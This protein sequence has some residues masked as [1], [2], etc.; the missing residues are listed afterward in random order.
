MDDRRARPEATLPRA[1]RGLFLLTALASALATASTTPA[2]AEI[3]VSGRIQDA[4]GHVPEGASVALVESLGEYERVALRADGGLDPEPIA[5][6]A[7]GKDGRFRFAA[8]RP[9]PYKVVVEAAGFVTMEHLLLPLLQNTAL[10]T[11]ELPA[12]REIVLRVSDAEGQALPAEIAFYP[13]SNPRDTWRP[14]VRKLTTDDKGRVA[15]PH[16][17]GEDELRLDVLADGRPLLSLDIDA[18]DLDTEKLEKEAPEIRLEDGVTGTVRVLDPRG[19]PAEDVV[20]FQGAGLLPFGKTDADGLITLTLETG[21]EPR[22]VGFLAPDGANRFATIVFEGKVEELPLEDPITV[23]GRVLDLETRDPLV[24]A[25]VW[26]SR[27]ATAFTDNRGRYEVHLPPMR[28]FSVRATAEG[29]GIGAA[30]AG[31]AQGDGEKSVDMPLALPRA[32][33]ARGRVVDGESRPV[34]DVKIKALPTSQEAF[35]HMMRTGRG[36][37]NPSTSG[38]SDADGRFELAFLPAATGFTL[39]LEKEGFSPVRHEVPPA[40]EGAGRPAIEIRMEAGRVGVGQVVDAAGEP[41]AGATVALGR[42]E[43]DK[44]SPMFFIMNQAED[45]KNG[46]A[47]D[48][49][50]RFRLP[51]LANGV[52]DLEV[53]ADGYAPAEIP[54]VRIEGPPGEVDLGTVVLEIGLAVSGLVVDPNGAPVAEAG[55]SVERNRQDFRMRR[56]GDETP[57]TRTDTTGRF[58]VGP[59]REGESLL[60]VVG[61]EGFT[62]ARHS[63]KI[64]ADP[65]PLRIVLKAA[66]R[67]SGRVVD[68]DGEPVVS[69]WLSARPLDREAWQ[70]MRTSARTDED[71]RFLIDNLDPGPTTLMV[72]AEGFQP[73]ELTGLELVAGQEL[74]DVD[75]VLKRGATIVGTVRDADGRPVAQAR[76]MIQRMSG[77]GGMMSTRGEETDADGRF[78]LT[79]VAAGPAILVVQDASRRETKKSIE[80]RSGSQTVDLAFEEGVEVSGRVVDP[81]GAPVAGANV[82]LEPAFTSGRAIYRSSSGLQTA[83]DGSFTF[84]DVLEGSYH[85]A[86]SKTGFARTRR[87]EPLEIEG[88][89]VRGLEIALERGA[90]LTGQILGLSFDDLARVQIQAW[91]DSGGQGTGRADYEGQYT[92]EGLAPGGWSVTAWVGDHGGRRVSEQLTITSDQRQATLDLEFTSGH[93]LRGVVVRNGAPVEGVRVYAANFEVGSSGSAMTDSSGRFRLEHLPTG[94]YQ[95]MAQS[96]GGSFE[97]NRQIVELLGDEDIRLELASL[98]LAGVVLGATDREPVAGAEL[99]AEKL[100]EGEAHASTSARSDSRG[101]FRMNVGAGTWRLAASRD[102]YAAAELVVDAK[103]VGRDDLELVLQPTEALVFE[104]ALTSGGVPDHVNVAVLGDDGPRAITTGLHPVLDDGT[105]RLTTL[106]PGPV[107][108][109]IHTATTAT[110]TLTTQAPGHA[111]RVTLEPAGTLHLSVPE[112]ADGG[113]VT[114]VVLTGSD[115]RPHV[116]SYYQQMPQLE[117][118]PSWPMW[119][120][121]ATILQIPTGTWRYT[122]IH[123]DGRTWEGTTTITAGAETTVKVP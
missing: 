61:K 68:A 56:R 93:T 58:T 23:S 99:R 49:D 54:G 48:T 69:A 28:R 109:L 106:P 79:G 113:G 22:S 15:I 65:E 1:L 63:V 92:I 108:L 40:P 88:V 12:A 6:A 110:A 41:V 47:T 100:D 95:V 96:A 50:G 26:T 81:D 24:D 57:D 53:T 71:G 2:D 11:L 94:T 66:A 104:V 67:L 19:E 5:R 17:D 118:K 75:V 10:P 16:Y 111:G 32:A 98:H 123:P 42:K 3:N 7:L 74:G 29:Y 89:D 8:P 20:V 122:V 51:D 27:G 117:R 115:G 77:G 34:A 70:A 35:I 84:R 59:A 36:F 97:Q 114:E 37:D 86:T 80:I 73:F 120:G 30:R 64:T 9:G 91:S 4:A 107:T 14:R 31:A 85:L 39:S 62:Q 105:V 101:R 45:G 38:R 60:V 43:R 13:K 112:L 102:G 76:V 83:A 52:F 72:R 103:G 55:V 33:A 87:P 44:G 78:R 18:E 90:V 116:P 25:F 46:D 119:N 82:F 21:D 121:Q